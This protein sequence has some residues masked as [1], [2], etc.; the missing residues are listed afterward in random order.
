MV[1][2]E[3]LVGW[4]VGGLVGWLVGLFFSTQ[5]TQCMGHVT[6][7]SRGDGGKLCIL[8]G[9]HS[10]LKTIWYWHATTIFSSLG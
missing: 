10:S 2:F 6:T 5:P 4:L 3:W 9:Q 7:G 1:T 8:V